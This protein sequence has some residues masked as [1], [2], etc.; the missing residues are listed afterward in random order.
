MGF[1][2]SVSYLPQKWN[3]QYMENCDFYWACL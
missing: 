1:A 2:L 3:A